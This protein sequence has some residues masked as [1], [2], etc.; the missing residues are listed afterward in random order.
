MLKYKTNLILKLLLILSI[1]FLQNKTFPQNLLPNGSF[2]SLYNNKN[3][4]FPWI[5]INTIDFFLETEQLSIIKINNKLDKNFTIRKAHSYPAYI[6]MRIKQDYREF[7]QLKLPSPLIKN[8]RY[9]FEMYV[10]PSKYCKYYVQSLGVSFYE[11]K[12]AYAFDNIVSKFQPQIIF[13]NKRGLGHN[14]PNDEW[15]KVSAEYIAKGGEKYITIGNFSNKK[16]IIPKSIISKFFKKEAYIY[17][18]DL[19]LA[20]LDVSFDEKI[21]Y[22]TNQIKDS[23]YYYDNYNIDSLQNN[24]YIIFKN[25]FFSHNSAKLLPESY[26]KLQLL[27]QYLNENPDLSI[28]IIGHTDNTGNKQYNKKLSYLR[29]KSVYNFLI[30]NNIDKNRLKY[31]G[32]GDTEPITTD[33]TNESRSLNRRVEIKIVN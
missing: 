8:H 28:E 13:Y 16:R 1:I 5:K 10:S 11:K 7:I 12:L 33:N 17:I 9:H 25:I 21:N 2:D 3:S 4:I 20:D 30:S 22:T 24:N 18:D 23:T 14:S 26:H 31:Y 19:Y 27:L 32:K 15:L 6:G 29:A